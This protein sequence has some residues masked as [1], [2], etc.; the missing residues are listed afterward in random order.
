MG[1]VGFA[2]GKDVFGSVVCVVTYNLYYTI[3]Q[4]FEQRWFG[5]MLVIKGALNP[6]FLNL[7]TNREKF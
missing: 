2:K 3:C 5:A 1:N 7:T 4:K 6:N